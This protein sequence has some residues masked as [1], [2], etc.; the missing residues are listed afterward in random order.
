MLNPLLG[1]Q[2]MLMS[3]PETMQ[4]MINPMMQQMMSNPGNM[5][6]L[7]GSMQRMQ[8]LMD[9]NPEVNHLL[10]NPDVLRESLEMVR[11]PAALQEVMRNYDRALNN[12]ESMPG[13]HNVLRRMYTEFQEPLLSAFQEEFTTNNNDNTNSTTGDTTSNNPEQQRTENRD[14]LPNP[15]ASSAPAAAATNNRPSF[16]GA[17][18]L[19]ALGGAGGGGT[20]GLG[21]GGLAGLAGLGAALGG[22]GGAGGLGGLAGLGLGANSDNSSQQNAANPAD[23]LRG[24]TSMFQDQEFLSLMTNPEAMQSVEQIRQG[25]ERLQRISPGLFGQLNFPTLPGLGNLTNTTISS[26]HESTGTQT[27]TTSSSTPPPPSATTTTTTS[28]VSNNNDN[29][30]SDPAANNNNNPASAGNLGDVQQRLQQMLISN[31]EAMQNM[32][33]PMMQQLMSNPNSMR[34]LFGGMQRMQSLM[35]QNPEVN[36][37]LSNPEVLRESLE[38]VRNPAAFQE[39]MRNYDRALNNMESM[40]GGFNALRRIYSEFQEPLLG[41]FQDSSQFSPQSNTTTTDTNTRPAGQQNTENRDPLPNPWAT[42]AAPPAPVPPTSTPT[43]QTT[44]TTNTTTDNRSQNPLA[45]NPLFAGLFNRDNTSSQNN[46]NSGQ[47]D[48]AD[49]IQTAAS[50]LQDQDIISLVTNPEAMQSMEQIRQGFERLQRIAP[51]LF[52]RLGLPQFPM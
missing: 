37:L 17:D 7:L 21:G 39:V 22:A 8:M 45:S 29:N 35:E 18:L 15:W 51:G 1:L 16:P 33:N 24:A 38:M 46:N 32:I 49:L 19:A 2:Q 26:N 11:N 50:A 6:S 44:T 48:P 47:P 30:P 23:L 31:P 10:S 36:H 40:P 12:M 27:N 13:G 41:A 25:F 20:G 52:G 28:N 42:P 14:P 5:R 34:S 9:Q 4:N 3:N 43:T